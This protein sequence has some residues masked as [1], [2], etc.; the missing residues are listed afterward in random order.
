M[1]ARIAQLRAHLRRRRHD[2]EARATLDALLASRVP[3]TVSAVDRIMQHY[4]GDRFVRKQRAALSASLFRTATVERSSI[5][6]LA[7]WIPVSS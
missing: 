4:Y 3:V 6:G 7:A 2:A 5:E 1:N